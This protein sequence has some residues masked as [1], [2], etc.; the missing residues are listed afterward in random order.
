MRFRILLPIVLFALRRR[1]DITCKI[2]RAAERRKH[3]PGRARD[4]SHHQ[5][6]ADKTGTHE[7]R[8]GA[9]EL[10]GLPV[11]R[12]V[13]ILHIRRRNI[14]SEIPSTFAI[15]LMLAPSLRA[16][17]WRIVSSSHARTAAGQWITATLRS[18]FEFRAE[19]SEYPASIAAR[20]RFFPDF[21][22]SANM[23]CR[24]VSRGLLL[25]TTLLLTCAR[26]GVRFVRFGL[27]RVRA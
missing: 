19:A 23:S 16:V 22:P 14:A 1:G 4:I 13:Y 18:V 6:A 26:R 12:I 10:S 3:C 21:K 7:P 27:L 8:L 9:R 24:L 15:L 25:T 17:R 20:Y 5:N 2:S 11:A